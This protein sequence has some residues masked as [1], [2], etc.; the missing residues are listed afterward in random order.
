[1]WRAHSSV[2]AGSHDHSVDATI[3][4]VAIRKRARELDRGADA[5]KAITRPEPG[6]HDRR[7]SDV[8][9][10][11]VAR[12]WPWRRKRSSVPSGVGEP[13]TLCGRPRAIP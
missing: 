7:D 1:L 11:I 6:R 3:G 2:V 13:S 10:A 9:D 5:A 8:A 4:T 12:R